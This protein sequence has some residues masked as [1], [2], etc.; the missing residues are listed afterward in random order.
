MMD[1]W[2]EYRAES[3]AALEKVCRRLGSIDGKLENINLEFAGIKKST[4]MMTEEC[5]YDALQDS[6]SLGE[7]HFNYIER[8]IKGISEMKD[9]TVVKGEYD[10]VMTS[11]DAVGVVETKYRVRKDDV[12]DLADRK[13]KSFRVLFPHYDDRP[14]YLGIGGLSFDEG[15]KDAAKDLGIAVLKVKGEK[16]EVGGKE[17]K[18]Y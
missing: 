11:R 18:V 1:K 6:L 15:A 12:L 17:L 7:V 16:V 2:E 13:V 10:L 4:G 9:G 14:I 5:F 3:V 8:N